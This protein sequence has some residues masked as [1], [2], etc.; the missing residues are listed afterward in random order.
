MDRWIGHATERKKRRMEFKE[1]HNTNEKKACFFC[2]GNEHLTPKE[3][4]RVEYKNSW[5]IR[6][7]PNKFP[8]VELK[9]N[10]K[11]GFL[12]T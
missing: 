5:K 2:S 12:N 1:I 4:G 10:A 3:I 8:T 7:F 11:K 6:W 9:E